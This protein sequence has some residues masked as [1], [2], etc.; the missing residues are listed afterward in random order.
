M[1]NYTTRQQSC[2]WSGCTGR[3]LP[4]YYSKIPQKVTGFDTVSGVIHCIGGSGRKLAGGPNDSRDTA[5][6]LAILCNSLGLNQ[7]EAFGGMNWFFMA[8]SNAG[9]L[10]R[11]LGQELKLNPDGPA[12]YPKTVQETGLPAEW[13][14]KFLK[15]VAL[16]EG[17]G[18]LWAE[19]VPRAAEKLGL[20]AEAR[21]THKLGYGPH[22]DGRYN[23]FIRFPV[24]VVSALSWATQGRDPYN[25]QHGYVERYPAS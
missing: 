9:K 13:G 1:G 16:R 2:A 20:E 6:E 21:K 19:G 14:V 5:R 11:I 4:T 7:W 22:W 18:D 12:V 8:C 17:D 25:Q 24:W 23:Q 3:C 15:A 10:P